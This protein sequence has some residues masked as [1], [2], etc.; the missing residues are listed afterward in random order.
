MKSVI[1]FLILVALMSPAFPQSFET[2]PLSKSKI[3]Q[4]GFLVGDWKGSGWRMG[5]EGRATFDQ[6]EKIR[7]K[8]DS[9]AILIEGKGRSN[10]RVVHNALAILTYNKSDESY[11]FRS[12][13]Q[14]GQ[15]AEFKGELIGDKFYWYPTDQVRYIIW[16]NEEG[17]WYEKGEFRRGDSWSQFLEM[18][19]DKSTRSH[20]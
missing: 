14:N 1:S 20:P 5:P 12:Y 4:L 19:L 17:Q 8:L 13:L 6:T 10:G 11:S 15:N 3:I 18:T 7:F 2:D 16:I 9:T